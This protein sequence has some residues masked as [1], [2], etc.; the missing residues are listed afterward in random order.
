MVAHVVDEFC[1]LKDYIVMVLDQDV[2]GE[3][4]RYR[5]GGQTYTP[6]ALGATT[7]PIPRNYIAVKSKGSFKGSAVELI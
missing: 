1:V 4:N 6:V 2:D 5:I 7:V 3:G